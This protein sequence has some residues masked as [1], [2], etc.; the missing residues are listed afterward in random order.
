MATD[1]ARL[2]L[3]KV[4]R[5]DGGILYVEIEREQ[6]VDAIFTSKSAVERILIPFYESLKPHE[7]KDL[8]MDLEQFRKD[9]KE[10]FEKYG[11][12]CV[13]HMVPCRSKAAAFA[14]NTRPPNRF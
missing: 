14:L 5:A 11:W 1:D 10:Q 3:V 7:L 13:P 4:Q 12:I 6:D 8:G 9:V 2:V